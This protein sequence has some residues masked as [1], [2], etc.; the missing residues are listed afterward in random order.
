MSEQALIDASIAARANAYAPYS[1][2]AVGAALLGEN[3]TIYTGVNVENVTF[4]LTTCA[5]QTAFLKAVSEGVRSFTKI[6]VCTE[7]S[8]P[9]AP[10]GLCR[11]MMVE[12]CEDLDILLVNP[13]GE[14]KRVRLSEIMPGPFRPRDL[15]DDAETER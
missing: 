1:N 13:A 15:L 14:M 4:G 3:G 11:Q 10:C 12:F 2:F 8:P 5:E 6:A 9:A 7:K